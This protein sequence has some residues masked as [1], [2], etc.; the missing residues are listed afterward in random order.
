[1]RIPNGKRWQALLAAATAL[2][3]LVSCAKADPAA[4][5]Q[6]ARADYDA[7]SY[8]AAAKE[9]AAAAQAGAGEEALRGSARCADALDDGSSASLAGRIAAYEALYSFGAFGP[10]DYGALAALYAASG[11]YVGER[12]MLEKQYRLAPADDVLAQL[13][14][15][16]VDPA[17]DLAETAKLVE[18]LRAA[19]AAGD[20]D[21]AAAAIT[22]DMAFDLLFPKLDRGH[23]RYIV[24][25]ADPAAV[26][27]VQAGY[28]DAGARCLD[29]WYT[30]GAGKARFLGYRGGAILTY[31]EAAASGTAYDGAFSLWCCDAADGTVTQ[32]S[33]TFAAGICT[34]ALAA[35]RGSGGAGTAAELWAARE[36]TAAAEFAGTFGADGLTQEKQQTAVTGADGVVYA[37]DAAQ[38]EFLYLTS[39]GADAGSFVFTSDA[40]GVPALP[41]WTLGAQ[42]P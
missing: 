38:K 25:S 18:T 4:L 30:D 10:E 29:C 8:A 34:G 1:M 6:R 26:L 39:T 28:D 20:A 40:L 41:S 32:E 12:D 9:Y 35:R 31:A 5:L 36:S 16:A 24:S 33:G 19:L 2:L 13:S 17:Q 3:L 7:G 23:R 14:A 42:T 11:N 22:G 27:R 37:Y 15:L 21:A